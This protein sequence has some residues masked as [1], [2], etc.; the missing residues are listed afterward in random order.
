MKRRW[1]EDTTDIIEWFYITGE[2]SYS[3]NENDITPSEIMS[4]VAGSI[5]VPVRQYSIINWVVK[6]QDTEGGL[7]S[8]LVG[9]RLGI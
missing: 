7:K 1:V 4:P 3:W 2:S 5:Q 9:F 8:S 6:G